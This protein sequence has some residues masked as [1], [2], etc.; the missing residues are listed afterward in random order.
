MLEQIVDAM[1]KR[2]LY[3]NYMYFPDAGHGFN[4]EADSLR[5]FSEAEDFLA[6]YIGGRAGNR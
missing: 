3:V 6:E 5:F 2:G 4:T 1:K